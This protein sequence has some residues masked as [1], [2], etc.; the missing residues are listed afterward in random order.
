MRYFSGWKALLSYIDLDFS[1]HLSEIGFIPLVI[2]A[3]VKLPRQA[4]EKIET[5]AWE[6]SLC[7]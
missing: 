4:F 1:L 6:C 3:A 7:E 5:C 2:W